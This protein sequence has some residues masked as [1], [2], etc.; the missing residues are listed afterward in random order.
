[1]GDD[2]VIQWKA[3]PLRPEP[4]PAVTFKGTSREEGWRR[5]SAMGAADGAAFRIWDRDDYATWSL[6]ALEAAK[7]AAL[8]GPGAFARRDAA[9]FRAFFQE[10]SIT[11][12]REK[13][14]PI[15]VAPGLDLPR[16]LADFDSGR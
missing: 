11:T 12:R 14:L 7:G 13:P 2:L 10:P 6:P 16:F 5:A 9:L 1:M 15:P 3:F 8:Q 4:D